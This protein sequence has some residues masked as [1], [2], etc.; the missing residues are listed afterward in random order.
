MSIKDRLNDAQ[1]LRSQS[2]FDG[3]LLMDLVAFAATARKRYPLPC[4]DKKAFI[5]FFN[6]ERA[7][8]DGGPHQKPP[9]PPPGPIPDDLADILYQ[10]LRCNLIHEG[11]VGDKIEWDDQGL[12]FNIYDG[13]AFINVAPALLSRLERAIR[14]APENAAEFAQA[15]N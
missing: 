1:A 3:A 14:C 15:T 11:K 7:T 5:R 13:K 6:D 2:R 12:G 8:I 4:K 10:Y 9:L